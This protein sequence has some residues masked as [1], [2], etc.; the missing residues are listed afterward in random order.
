MLSLLRLCVH[1][2]DG[3]RA[4]LIENQSYLSRD[5]YILQEFFI[6]VNFGPKSRKLTQKTYRQLRFTDNHNL[7]N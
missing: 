6:D 2:Q 4:E 3:G 7:S 5:Y 1:C